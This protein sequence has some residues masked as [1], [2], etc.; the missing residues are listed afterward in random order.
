MSGEIAS[1]MGLVGWVQAS[2]RSLK[3]RQEGR[4]SSRQ[5]KVLETLTLG[6]KR[7]LVL[8]RCGDDCFLVGTGS[9]SVTA[10]ER[11]EMGARA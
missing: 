3:A 10:I 1:G 8:V 11:V 4:E 7:Q 2:M 6:P 9:D 5:M